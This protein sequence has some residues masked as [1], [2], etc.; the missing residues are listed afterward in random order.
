VAEALFD[1]GVGAAIL[2]AYH[3]GKQAERR[4]V[5]KWLRFLRG[6]V[7]STRHLAAAISV[8]QHYDCGE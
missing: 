6:E 7:A 3:A 4:Q 2:A 5:R 1:L 8:G